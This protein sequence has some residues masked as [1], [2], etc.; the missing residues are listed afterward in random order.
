MRFRGVGVLMKRIVAPF[1]AFNPG[2]AVFLAATSAAGYSGQIIVKPSVCFIPRRKGT[3]HG[4]QHR[5]LP[6]L[7]FGLTA[8]S[9]LAGGRHDPV[10]PLQ[11]DISTRWTGAAAYH[12]GVSSGP[13]DYQRTFTASGTNGC[14]GADGNSGGR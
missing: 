6:F 11:Y 4:A 12:G 10:Y 5:N 1:P 9:A 13:G 8:G 14:C 7:S 2:R 3:A